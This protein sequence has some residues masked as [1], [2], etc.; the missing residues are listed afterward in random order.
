MPRIQLLFSTIALFVRTELLCSSIC[1]LP[2][3]RANRVAEIE[4]SPIRLICKESP[5]FQLLA[6]PR[7]IEIKEMGFF[8]TLPFLVDYVYHLLL[9]R[10]LKILLNN[11]IHVHG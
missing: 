6:R 3:N 9:L 2:P 11:P 7:N 4:G 1:R 8:L 10:N 5:F